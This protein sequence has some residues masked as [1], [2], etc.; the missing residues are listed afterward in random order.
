MPTYAY[1]TTAT[2]SLTTPPGSPRIVI[3]TRQG[4]GVG[5][6]C[7][8]PAKILEVETQDERATDPGAFCSVISPQTTV[9]LVG[10]C[11]TSV[12]HMLAMAFDD[13][14]MDADLRQTLAAHEIV[15]D[16]EWVAVE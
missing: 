6:Y 1:I 15:M 10:G 14:S 16:A 4:K 11:G 5:I 12:T 13:P 2:G 3:H 8:Q 7:D 9:K